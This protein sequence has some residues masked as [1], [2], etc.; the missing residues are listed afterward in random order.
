MPT[1]IKFSEALDNTHSAI[2]LAT[3]LLGQNFVTVHSPWS[4]AL[5]ATGMALAFIC[6]LLLLIAACKHNEQ[7]SGIIRPNDN[8]P[9]Y[10]YPIVMP[11]MFSNYHSMPMA[12]FQMQDRNRLSPI[13]RGRYDYPV[14]YN[15]GRSDLPGFGPYLIY[16]PSI[17]HAQTLYHPPERSFRDGHPPVYEEY[18][19]SKRP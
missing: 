17:E 12:N 14:S 10:G 13:D 19:S 8:L 5:T 18:A 1:V 11:T 7:T 4:M 2:A 6:C 9:P 15:H 3:Q 16:N